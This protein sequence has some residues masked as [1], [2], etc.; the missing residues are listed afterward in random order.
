[1]QFYWEG[2][3]GGADWEDYSS[4]ASDILRFARNPVSGVNENLEFK[5]QLTCLNVNGTNWPAYVPGSNANVADFF[6]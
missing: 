3:P 2:K 4:R 5:G 1:L 6:S